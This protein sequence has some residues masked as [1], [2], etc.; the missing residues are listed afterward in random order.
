MSMGHSPQLT[1]EA[2]RAGRAILRWSAAKLSEESGVSR[3]IIA[4]LEN[5][6]PVAELALNRIILALRR[7]GVEIL[8]EDG[9]GVRWVR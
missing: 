3:N 2:C 4:K 8:G 6:G 5:G 1:P 7:H 9:A